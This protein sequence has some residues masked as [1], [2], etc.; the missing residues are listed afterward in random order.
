MGSIGSWSC[1]PLI[2]PMLIP[3]GSVLGPILFI[4]YINDLNDC[5][6]AYTVCNMYLSAMMQKFLVTILHRFKTALI[7]WCHGW[8]I[9]S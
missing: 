7:K 2:L 9:T 4:I 5:C 6:L 3:Q 8:R 1:L